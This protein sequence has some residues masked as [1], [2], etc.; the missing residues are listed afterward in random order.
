MSFSKGRDEIEAS[1]Y[2]D[3]SMVLP[4]ATFWTGGGVKPRGVVTHDVL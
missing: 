4:Q 2:S 1:H 3:D